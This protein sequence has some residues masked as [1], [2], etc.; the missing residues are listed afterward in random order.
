MT[1]SETTLTA[2]QAALLAERQQRCSRFCYSQLTQSHSYL[3]LGSSSD[4]RSIIAKSLILQV[5]RVALD[6]RALLTEATW[7]LIEK[8][9]L[10]AAEVIYDRVD[11][12]AFSP[13]ISNLATTYHELVSGEL[14]HPAGGFYWKPKAHSRMAMTVTD[15]Q[16]LR[17]LSFIGGVHSDAGHR[18][19]TKPGQVMGLVVD[20]MNRMFDLTWLAPDDGGSPITGYRVEFSP[21][22]VTWLE[23]VANT[24]PVLM[25]SLAGPAEITQYFRVSAINA[26]GTGEVSEVVSS[27]AD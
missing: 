12:Q 7:A 8:Q 19:L 5:A 4:S 27:A 14:A 20:A 23:L 15:Q 17:W 6:G 22:N 2:E 16:V 3:I 10:I 25:Y 9:L 13:V 21:D 26:I 18:V 24:G 11:V 1:T